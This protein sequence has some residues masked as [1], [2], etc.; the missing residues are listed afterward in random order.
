MVVLELIL[1]YLATTLL[2]S[3]T[4]Y[5]VVRLLAPE[6]LRRYALMMLPLV[7]YCVIAIGGSFLNSTILNMAQATW[8]ILAAASALNLYVLLKDRRIGLPFSWREEGVV[9]G[10]SVLSYTIGVLPLVHAGSTAFLGVQWDL[11]I[12]LPLTEYLKRFPVRE[13][14]YAPANPLLETLN[15]IPV[16]GGSGWGFSYVEAVVDTV[17]GWPSYLSF[18]PLLHLVYSLSIPSLYLFCRSMLGASV[19]VSIGASLLWAANGL[20]LWIASV[21]LA[22]HAAMFFALPL[23]ITVCYRAII[24][25]NRGPLA[26]A[27]VIVAGTLLSFYTGS[28]P[29]LALPLGVMTLFLMVRGGGRRILVRA[30]AIAVLVGLFG[31]FGHLRFLQVVPLYYTQGFTEGWLNPDFSS[32]AQPLG[33]WPYLD[34]EAKIGYKELVGEA[35]APVARVMVAPLVGLALLIGLAGVLRGEWSRPL[36]VALALSYVLFGLFL[37]FIAPY[38][39]GYFKLLSLSHFL[40]MPAL[41]QGMVVLWRGLSPARAWAAIEVEEA[42]ARGSSGAL[43]A[44]LR[45]GMTLLGGV[46]ALVVVSNTTLSV[47]FF[48]W[49]A[50]GELPRQVWEMDALK[51]R[52]PRGETVYVSSSEGSN[53][54]VS[55]MIS[56]FL[57]DNPIAGHVKTAYGEV[58][59]PVSSEEYQYLLVQGG[60]FPQSVGLAGVTREDRLWENSLGTLYR[61]PSSWLAALDLD[62]AGAAAQVTSTEPLILALAPESWELKYNEAEF[63]GRNARPET[64]Q[65]VELTLLSFQDKQASVELNGKIE[66]VTVPNGLVLYRTAVVGTPAILKLFHEDSDPLW[67]LSAR[68]LSPQSHDPL[69]LPMDNSIAVSAKSSG[70]GLGQ[71]LDVQYVARNSLGGNLILGVELYG[72]GGGP[73][74]IRQKMIWPLTYVRE[75]GNGNVTFNLM[76][77]LQLCMDSSSGESR[78]VKA[79]SSLSL[80]DD[81]YRVHLVAYYANQELARWPW[82]M[83]NVEGGRAYG[84]RGRIYDPYFVSGVPV[85]NDA[86]AIGDIA[87]PGASIFLSSTVHPDRSFIPAMVWPLKERHLF[88]DAPRPESPVAIADPSVI[89]DYALLDVDE[90]PEPYGYREKDV[91][92]WNQ[93]AKMYRRGKGGPAALFRWTSGLD[94][95]SLR[96]GEGIEMNLGPGSVSLALPAGREHISKGP[97]A[98]DGVQVEI[99]VAASQRG[100]AMIT[101]ERE[102]QKVE[103]PRG[104]SVYKS[105]TMKAP[106]LL[107]L[108]AD[109]PGPLMVRSVAIVSPS[110]AAGSTPIGDAALLKARSTLVGGVA[111]VM[112]DYFG[113]GDGGF[114]ALD[115]YSL[116]GCS[117][118]HYGWWASEADAVLPGSSITLDLVSK[119]GGLTLPDGSEVPLGFQTWP[120]GDGQYRAFLQIKRGE[121]YQTVAAFDFTVQDGKV[122]GFTDYRVDAVL[123]MGG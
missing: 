40:L 75:Q 74:L 37:R 94:S 120:T 33:L 50:F 123:S 3:Y 51:Q 108:T 32:L 112:V 62:G 15:S 88:S 4:G 92:W 56:Y 31:F 38:P 78:P 97:L 11:E 111:Q 83:F 73:A 95:P 85:L 77:H 19:G 17:L 55:G 68:I 89:Y 12:Y 23:S 86:L 63:Q 7:G 64:N 10:L 21:G 22:G 81:L 34:V 93:E 46:F 91:V 14:I 60:Q 6:G 66:R 105:R 106:A 49:P 96:Q 109:G 70:E 28:L 20:G 102:T 36:F 5:G 84:V 41:A 61:T 116:G 42:T 110:S 13:A 117:E 72:K 80:P 121:N 67:V 54:W 69:L 8:V 18:R 1:F 43:R 47:L 35:L 87:L 71:V 113:P 24:D 44:L 57:I 52:L 29:L 103:I 98:R 30:F 100:T 101:T 90:Q 76:E 58:S 27:A 82:L 16:R 39:Y 2:L 118:A 119:T 65:Q 114:L 9:I 53:R 115:V 25:N 104:L 45:V 99:T 107:K 122:A 48:W 79:S 26:L 59:S